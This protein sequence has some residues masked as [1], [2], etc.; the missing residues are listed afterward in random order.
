MHEANK[1]CFSPASSDQSKDFLKSMLTDK[2]D[3]SSTPSENGQRRKRLRKQPSRSSVSTMKDLNA[4][5]AKVEAS[6][7]ENRSGMPETPKAQLGRGQKSHKSQHSIALPTYTARAV[8]SSPPSMAASTLHLDSRQGQFAYHPGSSQFGPQTPG[9]GAPASKSVLYY[10]GP[11]SAFASNPS[12][13]IGPYGMV[14]TMLKLGSGLQQS[15]HQNLI[16]NRPARTNG[17]LGGSFGQNF[18]PDRQMPTGPGYLPPNQ[19]FPP[20]NGFGW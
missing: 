15:S 9:A 6:L 11:S 8:I 10:T 16:P 19:R 5:L 20:T 17:Q 3:I 14:N 12:S 7:T 18:G 2:L 4:R 1:T 13:H